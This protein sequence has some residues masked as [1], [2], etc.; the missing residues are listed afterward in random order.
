MLLLKLAVIISLVCGLWACGIGQNEVS[1]Q[2]E[3]NLC[4]GY[5]L[6][7]IEVD[8]EIEVTVRAPGCFSSSCTSLKFAE[9]EII[10]DGDELVI[11]SEIVVRDRSRIEGACTTD[12]GIYSAKCQ[13]PALAEGEYTVRHGEESLT[14]EVPF[15]EPHCDHGY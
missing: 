9:C 11:Y 7:S 3:G 2:D 4:F 10:I 12:C 13:A 1:F 8:Q 5:Y 6:G 15:D 14:L